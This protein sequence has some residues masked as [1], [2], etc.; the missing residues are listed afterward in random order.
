MKVQTYAEVWV[1]GSAVQWS[2]F[3]HLD[4]SEGQRTRSLEDY[5]VALRNA[6][7]TA[8]FSD[9]GSEYKKASANFDSLIVEALTSDQKMA[10]LK[11]YS[12]YQWKSQLGRKVQK[13]DWIPG[14]DIVYICRSIPDDEVAVCRETGSELSQYLTKIYKMTRAW[15]RQLGPIL[16]GV[17]NDKGALIAHPDELSDMFKAVIKL[18]D[19]L[20]SHKPT[21][22]TDEYWGYWLKN[23]MFQ[24]HAPGLNLLDARKDIVYVSHVGFLRGY[25][26]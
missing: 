22:V 10:S 4:A 14:V 19:V 23:H 24:G 21:E 13:P 17:P 5:R 7:W 12:E 8:H 20:M 15:Q 3:E 1:L 25:E 6:D 2:K 26:G 18:W 9:D 11:Q 16:L